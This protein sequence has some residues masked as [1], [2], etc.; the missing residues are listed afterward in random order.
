[1]SKTKRQ[2]YVP[3][4]YLRNFSFNENQIFVFD[5][6]QQKVFTS[7]IGSVASAKF[8]Y[9]WDTLNSIV[10]EQFIETKFSKFES[11]I[12]V[13][14]KDLILSLENSSFSQI[15]NRTKHDI[16]EF[17]WY[18][19]I[20]NPEARIVG[21]QLHEIIMKSLDEDDTTKN[22]SKI[23]DEKAEHVKILLLGDV[24][25][26]VK[27]LVSKI[28]IIVKN[29]TNQSFYTSDNPVVHYTH[30]ELHH[31]AH[32]IF[33]PISPK[34]GLLIL[35]R[36]LFKEFEKYENKILILRDEEYITFYNFLQVTQATR[37][38]FSIANDLIHAEM[39]VKHNPQL[40]NM[41]RPRII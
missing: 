2:H 31:L 19:M 11:L 35:Y 20:R 33:Y 26:K 4:F 29:E 24:S 39:I 23:F 21:R 5:K 17:I 34:F 13:I 30:Q 15:I 16:A 10:G 22:K 32:E 9:E 40:S 41:N 25:M 38:I 3:Q 7:A 27:R 36:D 6:N 28:W 37:Q 1:M 12:S 8:F 18:Q 14:L